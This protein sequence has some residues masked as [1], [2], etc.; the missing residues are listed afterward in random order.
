MKH[1]SITHFPH[2]FDQYINH[3]HFKKNC[4]NVD[5]DQLPAKLIKTLEE[6]D[7]HPPSEETLREIYEA[8]KELKRNVKQL[9]EELNDKME[10]MQILGERIKTEKDAN[11]LDLVTELMQS[12]GIPDD[13]GT[14]QL[15]FHSG[16]QLYFHKNILV[17]IS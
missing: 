8:H 10:K 16:N 6:A 14:T 1:V 15:L 9:K 5:I 7:G 13:E 12:C 17:N 3:C 4:F 2:I 11:A